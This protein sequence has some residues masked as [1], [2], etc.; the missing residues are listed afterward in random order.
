MNNKYDNITVDDLLKNLPIYKDLVHQINALDSTYKVKIAA[1]YLRVST[2][3]QTEF[4]PEAQLE[5]IIK[6]CQKENIMLPKENIF[7][8]SGLSGTRADKRPEFQ[9]MM[10][11]AEDKKRPFDLILVHKYDRFA[12]NRED[13]IVYKSRLRKKLGIDIIAVKEQLPEDKKLAMM[14]ES[15]LETWG[16]YYSL[17]L[18][19]EVKKGQRKKAAR[20]ES[21]GPAPF[22]YK[23]I[24]KEVIKDKNRD[25]II[26]ELIVKHD[27]ADIIKKIFDKFINGE[28]IRE[29]TLWLN[30]LGIKTKRNGKF[31]D[32]AIIWIL[33]NPVYIGYI[34]WTENGMQRNWNNPD[35]I[36][37]K[38]THP[39]II[40]NETWDKAQK[41]LMKMNEM[42][43]NRKHKVKYEHWLRGLII[44]DNCGE[45]LVKNGKTFQC[46][47]Y[48]HARCNI[49][50]SITVAAVEDAILEQLKINFK[51][52][53]INIQISK[54]NF[55]NK[56]EI[57]ILQNQLNQIELKE[58]RVKLAYEN[59]IDTL[60]EYKE[61]KIR[62]QNDKDIILKEIKKKGIS[63]SEIEKRED[64][65][66][67]SESAYKILTDPA[68]SDEDK[69]LIAHT[70]IEKIVFIKSERKLV[71][72][73]K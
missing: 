20:G 53:P 15:Q 16:E 8:E 66:K 43:G 64:I 24:I 72:T 46:T 27:E 21:S 65:F 31:S 5:D 19:D 70:L 14:M 47:G 44:C 54:K 58:S 55:D 13:S 59:G 4:S 22:G 41:R 48:T 6:Y 63:K 11:K 32:R 42:Y 67:R 29:I 50:H 62:L 36:T 12:R 68:V 52:K 23:K 7:I 49:S 73:Y 17:N 34:R 18:S 3:M 25:K 56:D 1:A 71:I 69:T 61:N 40:D 10:L 9:R 39:A 30:T 57:A 26:R 33:N 45:L 60:E 28:T 38:S 51:S 35:T 37:K 2:D